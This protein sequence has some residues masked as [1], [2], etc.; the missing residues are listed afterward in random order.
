VYLRLSPHQYSKAETAR[1]YTGAQAD[2]RFGQHLPSQTVGKTS[3]R[4]KIP[5][6][7]DPHFVGRLK[8]Q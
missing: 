7:I 5:K 6:W 3:R 4:Y 2:T 8:Q 1:E